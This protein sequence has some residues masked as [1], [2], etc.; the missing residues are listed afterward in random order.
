MPQRPVGEVEPAR[1][2]DHQHPDFRD[3]HARAGVEFLHAEFDHQ[4]VGV[5]AGHQGAILPQAAQHDGSRLPARRASHPPPR[6][7]S[8]HCRDR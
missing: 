1:R 8:G 3:P 7:E 2:P 6:R 5:Q 4:L